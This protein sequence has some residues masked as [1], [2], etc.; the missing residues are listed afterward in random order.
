MGKLLYVGIGGLLFEDRT[1]EFSHQLSQVRAGLSR[2]F[3]LDLTAHCSLKRI[4]NKGKPEKA[5]SMGADAIPFVR[6]GQSD[7]AEQEG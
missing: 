4:G 1:V 2:Y 6:R 7:N 5:A 3:V